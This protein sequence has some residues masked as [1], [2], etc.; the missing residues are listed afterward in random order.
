MRR[1]FARAVVAFL[2]GCAAVVAAV[3]LGIVSAVTTP[4]IAQFP[5]SDPPDS[6]DYG[7]GMLMAIIGFYVFATLLI[8]MWIV[9]FRYLW[10]KCDADSFI[11]SGS[12]CSARS[13]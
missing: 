4:L 12:V 6:T 10:R 2:S 13:D 1:L 5:V 3:L 9:C 7:Q 11:A 8:P